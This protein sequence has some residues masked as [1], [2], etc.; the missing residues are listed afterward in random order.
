MKRKE[1]VN[2]VA[3]FSPT[4]MEISAIEQIET[5]IQDVSLYEEQRE[6]LMKKLWANLEKAHGS[7]VLSLVSPEGIV[8]QSPFEN[9]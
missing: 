6:S 9:A 2:K 1:R 4:P 8:I 5:A 7:R 3:W